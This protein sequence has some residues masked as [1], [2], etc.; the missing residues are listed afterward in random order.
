MREKKWHVFNKDNLPLTWDGQAVEFDTEKDAKR[1]LSSCLYT[2]PDM[3]R[4]GIE[5]TECI[6]YYDGGHINL[7]GCTVDTDGELVSP[8]EVLS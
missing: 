8:S 6:F 3:L 2:Y 1:F 4:D 7:S 5:I